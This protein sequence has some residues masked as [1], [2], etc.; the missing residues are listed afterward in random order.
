MVTSGFT[1]ETVPKEKNIH[2]NL[3]LKSQK[4]KQVK[5]WKLNIINNVSS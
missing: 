3:Y 2:L 1:P 4:E 5:S